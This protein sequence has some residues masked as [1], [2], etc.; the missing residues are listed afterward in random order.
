[1]PREKPK[2]AFS[3][4]SA[5]FRLQTWALVL[6]RQII[7]GRG[8]KVCIVKT[9]LDT[10]VFQW[11]SGAILSVLIL[12]VLEKLLLLS[13]LEGSNLV[14][15]TWLLLLQGAALSLWVIA[16]IWRGGVSCKTLWSLGVVVSVPC[17]KDVIDHSCSS[18]I[19]GGCRRE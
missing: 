5:I 6:K 14:P 15:K 16:L 7:R 10:N 17:H 2:K 13:S 19:P 3:P 4:S 11:W 1:M 9:V 18:L 12:Q 8:Q